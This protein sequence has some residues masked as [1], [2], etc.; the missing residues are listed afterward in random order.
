MCR[1]KP[2]FNEGGFCKHL[3]PGQ[4]VVN[5]ARAEINLSLRDSVSDRV[6]SASKNEIR[7]RHQ[8]EKDRLDDCFV[9]FLR[10]GFA[11]RARCKLWSLIQED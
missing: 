4:S 8:L 5:G 2:L 10:I 1:S 7:L 9:D 3:A 11:R 6:F